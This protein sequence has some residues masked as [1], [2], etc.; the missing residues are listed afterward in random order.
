MRHLVVEFI[1]RRRGHRWLVPSNQRGT[2]ASRGGN[3]LIQGETLVRPS[4]KRLLQLT[5]DKRFCCDRV[6]SNVDE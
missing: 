4:D 1:G 5:V 2:G 3:S 6:E